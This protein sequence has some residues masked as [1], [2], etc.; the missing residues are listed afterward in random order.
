MPDATREARR[1]GRDPTGDFLLAHLVEN[2]RLACVQFVDADQP[3]LAEGEQTLV[4][5]GSSEDALTAAAVRPIV[6]FDAYERGQEF[7]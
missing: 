5:D 1:H 6:S 2:G 3:F 7:R 4:G